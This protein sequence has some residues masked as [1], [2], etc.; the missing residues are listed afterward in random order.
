MRLWID[1]SH[2]QTA[3]PGDAASSRR[4]DGSLGR[5]T[6]AVQASFNLIA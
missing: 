1:R 3:S 5:F 4:R 2:P 6:I